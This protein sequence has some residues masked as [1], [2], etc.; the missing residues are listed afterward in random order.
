VRARNAVKPDHRQ[1]LAGL[2]QFRRPADRQDGKHPHRRSL[3]HVALERV[4]MI[5]DLKTIATRMYRWGAEMLLANVKAEGYWD[6]K[7]LTDELHQFLLRTALPASGEHCRGPDDVNCAR[8]EPAGQAA[9][10][11]RGRRRRDS[12]RPRR[13]RRLP[14]LR[15]PATGCKQDQSLDVSTNRAGDSKST[16]AQSQPRVGVRATAR[17]LRRQPPSHHA[18]GIEPLADLAWRP[19]GCRLDGRGG[20][21]CRDGLAATKWPER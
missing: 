5:Y 21:A 13:Q 14:R 2:E 8:S 19:G 20:D 3:L 17:R 10:Q 11:E 6:V 16:A 7:G 12:P 15:G 1:G 9:R 18:E 4:S